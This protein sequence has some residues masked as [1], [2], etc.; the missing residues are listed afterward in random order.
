MS[1]NSVEI[2]KKYQN[3]TDIQKKNM[4]FYPNY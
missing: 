4:P 2:L 1:P 3:L